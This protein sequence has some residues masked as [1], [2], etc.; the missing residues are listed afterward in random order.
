MPEIDIEQLKIKI[1]AQHDNDQKQ[2]DV[3]F[4]EASRLM[5]EAPAGYGKTTTMISRIAYLFAMGKIPNPK[6]LL[7]LTF[8]VNAALKIKRDIAEKLPSLI[9]RQNNPTVINEKV[10]ATNYHGFCKIV[11]KKYGFLITEILRRDVNLFRAVTDGN[12]D[13]IN[14]LEAVLSVKELDNIKNIESTIKAGTMPDE[15]NIMEYNELIVRKLLP[16]GYITH[17]AII[18]FTITLLSEN[19]EVQKFYQSYYPLII[20]D[21]FQDTNCISWK[22][23]TLLINEK[24]KLLFL[25]D[26]LQRI[27]GFIGALPN[28]MSLAV[29]TYNM[30]QVRLEKNYRFRSNPEM[31]KLDANIRA[32]AA[33]M[34]ICDPNMKTADLPAFFGQDQEDESTQIA[35][36]V[37]DL[38]KASENCRIAI[39]CRGRGCN[40]DC[41]EQS[42]SNAGV[43]YFYGM[44]T[45]DDPVYVDFH[46]K[47]Q[48]AF[49]RKFGKTKSI[50][51]RALLAFV[52]N[53][54]KSFPENHNKVVS[55]LLSLLDALVEKMSTDY[56]TVTPEDKYQLMI[57][58]LENRQLKQAMEYIDINVIVATVHGAKGL[59]WDYVF[60][61]DLERWIFPNY[62]I[63]SLCPQKFSPLI[64]YACHLDTSGIAGE[65]RDATI[66]ELS[67]FYV[68][69]TRAKKQV[70]VS[71]S[72]KRYNET[73]AV[74]RSGF[75][76][77]SSLSGIHLVKA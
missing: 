19:A 28:I 63:C 54:R 37:C 3:V 49:I 62:H 31:L 52:A 60:L 34:F 41:I 38:L 61:A 73:G 42:L 35:G 69:V 72:A 55:S 1:A 36:K 12:F 16:L 39:L 23:L 5:I 24:T 40:S 75:S 11:L 76:C 22:L 18:L 26:P 25:G 15:E 7:G 51:R 70:F 48:S 47:C 29:K 67:I 8:S 32:N 45:D 58:I 20:V 14:E 17:N 6:R 2:L 9:G 30:V 59:E 64:R 13:R 46:I 65:S 44:F 71:A 77:L 74:K 66:D 10:T 33:H 50:N 68:G 53:F 21:E 27:Y 4:S 57:D 43:S 56:A